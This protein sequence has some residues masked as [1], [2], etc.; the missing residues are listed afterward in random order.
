[1]GHKTVEGY[2]DPT[3]GIAMSRVMREYRQKQ[4]RRFAD[5]N[6]KKIY[7]VSKYAG[8]TGSN[9]RNAVKYCR[10]VIAE[11]GMPIASHLLYPASGILR[12]EIEAER[13]MGLMFGL[14]LLGICDEVW[15]FGDVSPGMET[16]IKEARRLNKPVMFKE[17]Q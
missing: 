7:V 17:V 9:I 12:D 1:M 2:A 4:R 15:V 16:E 14:A 10:Y 5:R 3:A 8:N 11:G 6:R 13:E